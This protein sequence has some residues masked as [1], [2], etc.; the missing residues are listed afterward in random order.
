MLCFCS[1]R[2]SHLFRYLSPNSLLLAFVCMCVSFLFCH[3]LTVFSLFSSVHIVLFL[4][5][6]RGRIMK[7]CSV[8]YERKQSFKLNFIRFHSL[9]CLH[10]H[11]HWA[12]AGA[13]CVWLAL[14]LMLFEIAPVDL[15]Y[16]RIYHAHTQH[17]KQQPTGKYS[18][19]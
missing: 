10:T 14:L 9:F 15:V 11:T 2:C 1:L 4:R 18:K 16:M 12:S 7:M 8:A 17:T 6:F 13:L 5:K 19:P 3:L